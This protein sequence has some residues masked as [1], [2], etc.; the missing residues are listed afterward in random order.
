MTHSNTERL[1][2]S[3]RQS[4]GGRSGHCLKVL[5]T[6]VIV[7]QLSG[8]QAT[9]NQDWTRQR[10]IPVVGVREQLASEPLGIAPIEY[11]INRAG[12]GG[13]RF[14]DVARLLDWI[15]SKRV[16]S[17][18]TVIQLTGLCRIHL[19]QVHNWENEGLIPSGT[20]QALIDQLC[21]ML[22]RGPRP[23]QNAGSPTRIAIH[24]RRGDVAN[25]QSRLFK[26]MGPGK[27]WNAEF[28]QQCVD[29]F[30]GLNPESEMTIYSE[31]INAADLRTIKGCELNLGH[32]KDVRRH[33][34]ALVNAD[35]LVPA[36]SSF[37]TWAAYLSAGE[38]HV[39]QREHIK[40]FA[41]VT[42]PDNFR[43]CELG[44]NSCND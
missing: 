4:S 36:N 9:F 21:Q 17:A 24:A 10:I 11:R 42:L 37:S 27:V 33:F 1:F 8:G 40:H 26:S 7:A 44:E 31:A 39:F 16:P 19:F 15:E 38:V 2:V 6:S 35:I 13:M 25:P 14:E 20:Y 34:R 41:H 32:R 43:F 29:H 30:R 5:F 3:Y 23:V 28:Y 22:W 12:W 18:T